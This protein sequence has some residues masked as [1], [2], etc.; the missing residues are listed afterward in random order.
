VP[1]NTSDPIII[2]PIPVSGSQ[3]SGG[4][5]EIKIGEHEIEI[6]EINTEIEI[7]IKE[8]ELNPPTNDPF[9]VKDLEDLINSVIIYQEDED[10]PI[11]DDQTNQEEDDQETT[12]EFMCCYDPSY[13]DQP[14]FLPFE[15]DDCTI[16]PGGYQVNLNQDECANDWVF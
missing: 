10:T 5:F 6:P 11:T 12:S 8:P 3:T 16:V 14:Y 9:T 4:G 15:G 7:K 13:P 1:E 2:T